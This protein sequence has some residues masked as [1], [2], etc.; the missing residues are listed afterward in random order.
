MPAAFRSAFL[1]LCL[2]LPLAAQETPQVVLPSD[3]IA[4]E[5]FTTGLAQANSIAFD[6]RGTAYLSNYRGEGIVG[7]ILPDGAACVLCDLNES[8]PAEGPA[9]RIACLRVDVEGRL[10]VADSGLGRLLRVSADGTRVEILADRYEGERFTAV[11]AVAIDRLG[12]IYFTDRGPAPAEAEDPEFEEAAAEP[13]AAGSLYKFDVQTNK[14]TVLDHDLLLPGGLAISP[15]QSRLVVAESAGDRL[16]AYPLS[17]QGEVGERQVLLELEPQ[18]PAWPTEPANPEETAAESEPQPVARIP[19]GMAFDEAG[20]LY[21]ALA[22]TGQVAAID[23]ETGEE[24]AAWYAGGEGA[25]DCHFQGDDLY[26]AIATKE[27]IFRLPLGIHGFDYR[28]E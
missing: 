19:A 23:L 10:I 27:A 4:P 3:D 5:L 21:V 12:D 7:R 1:L 22:G 25:S 13:F 28:G 15:D 16:L 18:P 6:G 8:A 14:V 17:P 26:V 20:R 24:L 2:S 11:E 9:P